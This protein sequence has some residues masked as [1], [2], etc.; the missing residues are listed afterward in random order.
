MADLKFD[1]VGRIDV[2]RVVGPLARLLRHLHQRE[3]ELWPRLWAHVRGCDD[4]DEL[5]RLLAL[6]EGRLA[7]LSSSA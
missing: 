7:L 1:T 5:R 2:A 4:E 6:V 3:A